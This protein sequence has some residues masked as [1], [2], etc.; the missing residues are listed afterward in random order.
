MDQVLTLDEKLKYN[1]EKY[2]ILFGVD[3]LINAVKSPYKTYFKIYL[4]V[5]RRLSSRST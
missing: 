5:Y 3:N 2:A 4:Y 1:F